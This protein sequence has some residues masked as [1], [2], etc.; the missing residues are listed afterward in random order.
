MTDRAQCLDQYDW[1]Y[2]QFVYSYDLY[3]CLGE[4]YVSVMTS[5]GDANLCAEINTSSHT[6][7]YEETFSSL[8]IPSGGTCTS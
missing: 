2:D 8:F 5:Q 6:V 7:L 4:L 1:K 3:K